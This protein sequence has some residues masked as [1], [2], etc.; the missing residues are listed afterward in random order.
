MPAPVVPLRPSRVDRYR[1]F[2]LETLAKFPTL[3]AVRLFVM[4]NERGYRGSAEHFRYVIAGMRP[5]PAA[6]AF[7]AIWIS[8]RRFSADV[9]RLY[10]ARS[11]AVHGGKLHGDPHGR[12]AESVNSL[13]LL[14]TA[15]I[16]R[17]CLPSSEDLVP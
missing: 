13:R 3:T 6:E 10:G 8:R 1:P 9:E 12:V 7:Q 2:I 14:I 17:N 16:E 5:R 4:V 15:C 11:K